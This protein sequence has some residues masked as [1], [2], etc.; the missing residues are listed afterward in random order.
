MLRN[1]VA[2]KETLR[3]LFSYRDIDLLREIELVGRGAKV[4]EKQTHETE[5]KS[6]KGLKSDDTCHTAYESPIL[7]KDKKI[8]HSSDTNIFQ[9]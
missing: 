7:E 1:G 8:D 6:S 2:Y 3:E 4:E 5:K 9:T